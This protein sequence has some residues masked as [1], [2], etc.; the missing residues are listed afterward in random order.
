MKTKK[1]FSLVLCFFMLSCALILPAYAD[2]SA[3]VAYVT[4]SRYGEIVNDKNGTPIACAPVSLSGQDGYTID[5]VLKEAHNLYFE[6]G[7]D[8]G[9]KTATTQL[10]LGITKLLGDESGRYGYY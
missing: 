6:G 4:F 7:A 2:D 10:G 3:I 8:A 1:I 5:D 9:Y